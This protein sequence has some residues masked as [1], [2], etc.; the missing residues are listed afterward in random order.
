MPSIARL[1]RFA[2][3]ERRV[4][5]R[6]LILLPLT[7]F[8]IRRLG[9]RRAQLL[10]MAAPRGAPASAAEPAARAARIARLVDVV[11][12]KGPFRASCLPASLTLQRLLSEAGIESQLRLGVR[13]VAG[14]LEAHAWIEREGV[15]LS[16]SAQAREGFAAF[17]GPVAPPAGAL[18]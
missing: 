7:A 15:A 4:V 5:A 12:R 3:W 11:A 17:D 18:R 1:L 9:L 2:P 8:R 6:A 10:A 13:K 14:R 16:D